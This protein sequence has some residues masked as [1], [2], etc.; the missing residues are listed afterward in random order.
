[1]RGSHFYYE[2][3]VASQRYHGTDTLTYDS[4]V[5]LKTNQV[6][7]VPL[8][9][10]SV[11]GVVKNSVN[12]PHFTTKS[13]TF[14]L[15]VTVPDA[16]FTVIDWLIT[17][18]PAPLGAIMQL[19][20]PSVLAHP[21]KQKTPT[22]IANNTPPVIL[23]P[24]TTEQQQ[25]INT[26]RRQDSTSILL[27]GVT[28]S[29]KTRVYLELAKETMQRGE[30]VLVL[31]PEI[32]LTPQLV[33][34][35]ARSFSGRVVTIHS[36]LT[37]AQKREVWLRIAQTKH[38]LIVIGPRSALF[39][40]LKRIGLIIID[41]AHDNAYK[42]EQAPYYQTTRVAA[43]LAKANDARLLLG[44]AT[45]LIDD[46]Y[47]FEAKK[48]TIATMSNPAQQI[49][50]QTMNTHVINLRERQ[51]FSRSPWL[52]NIL[53][54]AISQALT[55]QEQSLIFLNRRGTARLVICND[56]GWQA[57]CPRCDIPLTYHGDSHHLQ[58]HTCGFSDR[59]PTNCVT[60]L[61]GDITFRSIGTKALKTELQRLFPKAQIERFDSDNKKADRM[62][63]TFASVAQGA[64]DILVGT[65]ILGKGLDL[66]KLSVV[67][68]V[69][70]DTSLYFPDY[71][72]EERT[73]QM[74][75]QVL[76]RVGRGHRSSTVIVQSYNPE[77]PTIKHAVSRDYSSFYQAQITERQRY[78]FPPFFFVLK[79]RCGRRSQASAEQTAHK[80]AQHLLQ[81]KLP[82]EL[83][84]P[85]SAFIEKI[86]NVY[87]WQIIIKAKQR[88]VLTRII[89]ELPAN[90]S[91][92][93]DPTNLL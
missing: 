28:G 65:Q 59:A 71:T 82:I 50:K 58:C 16:T 89:Q 8:Q 88:T 78:H 63:N 4:D 68:V 24:L 23:P 60:C 86:N 41:E 49:K 83:I 22:E 57:L 69:V 17:Y 70:A 11:V 33:E 87:F 74:L 44:T 1:M 40:P 3:L 66:P 84:G 48:L 42:Q 19:F 39:S 93:I 21:I 27:H 34:Q 20:L 5:V 64:I 7:V 73:F 15:D 55:N 54:D 35:F 62:E 67:G 61:S 53:L 31:T 75:T 37:P 18:Y 91:Y 46:Y 85:S 90:W 47:M 72:A 12:K 76:G 51:H 25:A 36:T 26:I 14:S 38:P 77:N 81:Q 92:D 30:S 13:I 32:G 29:G 2:I 6:V 56:C 45:P 79:L 52:S 9:K 80:L 10:E 43:V